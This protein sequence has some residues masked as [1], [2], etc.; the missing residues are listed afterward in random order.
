MLRASWYRIP[1]ISMSPYVCICTAFYMYFICIYIYCKSSDFSVFHGTLFRVLGI[2]I[3][4]RYLCLGKFICERYLKATSIVYY[5]IIVI[6]LCF[7]ARELSDYQTN[8]RLV[9]ISVGFYAP[10]V[11]FWCTLSRCAVYHYKAQF[12]T[13]FYWCTNIL[14]C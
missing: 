12:V 14:M 13:G 2:H 11:H 3:N 4:S 1:G 8:A 7:I 5:T 6:L 9:F 10:L